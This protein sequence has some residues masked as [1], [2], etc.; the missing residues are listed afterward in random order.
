MHASWQLA[1]T[2]ASHRLQDILDALESTD[3]WNCRTVY[4]CG[5]DA[6]IW[7][8][9]EVDVEDFEDVVDVLPSVRNMSIQQIFEKRVDA[10]TSIAISLAMV[11]Q[12]QQ[13][14]ASIA[15][16]GTRIV[17]K[18][19]ASECLLWDCMARRFANLVLKQKTRVGEF[20]FG[21]NVDGT[22][23]KHSFAWSKDDR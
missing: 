3:S 2:N 6:S 4:D 20:S 7:F 12:Y 8:D 22:G 19:F 9:Q 11:K 10:N 1:Q 13:G 14:G 15:V 17:G 5:L 21:V 23:S 16:T 18:G